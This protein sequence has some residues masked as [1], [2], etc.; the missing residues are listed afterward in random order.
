M[1][2]RWTLPRVSTY[3]GGLWKNLTDEEKEK[4][5]RQARAEKEKREWQ[6]PVHGRAAAS[7]NATQR[8]GSHKKKAKTTTPIGPE[9]NEILQMMVEEREKESW[10]ITSLPFMAIGRYFDEL[11]LIFEDDKPSPDLSANAMVNSLD[12][13]QFSGNFAPRRSI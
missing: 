1:N 5:R 8:R 11:M 4:Y 10:A 3:A 13:M 2:L 12:S 9:E 6:N 7:G